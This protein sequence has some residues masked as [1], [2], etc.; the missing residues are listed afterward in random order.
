MI[1]I[2]NVCLKIR[3]PKNVRRSMSKKSRCRIRFEK[4]DGKRAK[5]MLKSE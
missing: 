3:T 2:P 4:Q 1:L 5:T